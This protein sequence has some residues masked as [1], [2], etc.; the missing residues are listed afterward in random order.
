MFF[1]Q[2][3]INA[4]VVVFAFES[5]L[6]F[7]IALVLS[8]ILFLLLRIKVEGKKRLLEPTLLDNAVDYT[9]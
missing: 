5:L 4:V 3:I 6:V 9:S 2:I 1:V 7:V 8:V